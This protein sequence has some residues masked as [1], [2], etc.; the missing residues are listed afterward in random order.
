MLK[1]LI[2]W[3]ALITS[4]LE[5]HMDGERAPVGRSSALQILQDPA[6][7]V[8][9][10]EH[11]PLGESDNRIVVGSVPYRLQLHKCRPKLPQ[12]VRR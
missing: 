1:N 10:S 4:F 6:C 3:P 9:L 5:E 7:L 8:N 2:R 11:V 12:R